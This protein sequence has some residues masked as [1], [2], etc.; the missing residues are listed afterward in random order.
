MEHI[1]AVIAYIPLTTAFTPKYEC[2]VYDELLEWRLLPAQVPGA[3]QQAAA[4]ALQ[5]LGR[6]QLCTYALFTHMFGGLLGQ[7]DCGSLALW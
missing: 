1:V 2:K 3:G 7:Q 5:M 4:I 6:C